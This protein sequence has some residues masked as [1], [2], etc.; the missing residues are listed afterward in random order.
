MTSPKIEA[1]QSRKAFCSECGWRGMA[2]ELAEMRC[3]VH[4]RNNGQEQYTLR[5]CPDCG[6]CESTVLTACDRIDCWLPATCGTP[7]E[8]GYARTCWRHNP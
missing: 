2:A 6:E 4:T 3:Q 7:T 1:E 8:E 5:V